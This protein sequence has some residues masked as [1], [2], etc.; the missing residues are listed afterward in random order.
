VIAPETEHKIQKQGY[1]HPQNSLGLSI[2]MGK[3]LI[4]E[5]DAC[6]GHPYL[7]LWFDI[8]DRGMQIMEHL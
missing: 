6:A 1:I 2:K 7:I 3:Y 8:H 4:S 5:W